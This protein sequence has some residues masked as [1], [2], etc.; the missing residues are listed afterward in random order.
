MKLPHNAECKV[1]TRPFTVFR[2]NPGTGLRPKKTEICQT[3]AKVKN[4]CQTCLLDLQ[5]GLPVQVRDAALELER[6]APQSAVNREYFAQNMDG[7]LKGNETLVNLGKASP[8]G[9]EILKRLARSEQYQKRNRPHICTFF[10]KGKCNRGNECPY[11]HEF[12]AKSDMPRGSIRDRYHG[13]NDP[14]ARKMLRE[15]VPNINLVPPLDE[16]IAS[17][18]VTDI[19]ASITEAQVRSAFDNSTIKSVVLAP[20]SGCGFINFLS[21]QAAEAAADK[22]ALHGSLSVKGKN[23]P[24]Q[25]AKP[26]PKTLSTV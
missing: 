21:R 4:V 16:S 22:I 26:R 10:V 19:D 20:S 13:T 6:T 2:W 1:C 3:C 18:F 23:L 24:V 8:A 14:I 7:K 9:K 5:F 25:W 12:P 15:I 11:R 17:L